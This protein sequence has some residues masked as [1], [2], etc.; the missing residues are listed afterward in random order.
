MVFYLPKVYEAIQIKNDSYEIPKRCESSLARQNDASAIIMLSFDHSRIT[1]VTSVSHNLYS[2]S[3]IA[4]CYHLH[5]SP[6]YQK[7]VH[8]DV[9]TTNDYVSGDVN[10]GVNGARFC[11]IITIN[12]CSWTCQCWYT[13]ASTKHTP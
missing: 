1:F 11:T 7:I 13:V 9:S 2:P 6:K 12:C 4:N 10:G 5:S 8:D 3:L